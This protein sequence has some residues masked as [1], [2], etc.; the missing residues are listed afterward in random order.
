MDNKSLVI[1]EDERDHYEAVL[2]DPFG[3]KTWRNTYII[4][5]IERIARAKADNVALRAQVERYEKS[6]YNAASERI[7]ELRV[8]LAEA[9]KAAEVAKLA[10][11]ESAHDH[12]C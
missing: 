4:K 1:P 7:T 2:A 5:L 9:R 11:Q 10:P 8:Y 12:A 3:E 6:P